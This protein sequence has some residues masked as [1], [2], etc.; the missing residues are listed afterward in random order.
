[1]KKPYASRATP[2]SRLQKLFD[3]GFVKAGQFFPALDDHRAF[4][5]IRILEHELD[6][7]V[8]RGRFLLH[9][10]VPVKRRPGIQKRLD[11]I[12]ADEVAQFLFG[13]RVLA[14]LS[15]VEIN[16]FRLQETSCFAASRSRRLVDEFDLLGHRGPC[17]LE[18]FCHALKSQPRKL[19][20]SRIISMSLSQ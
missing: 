5:Q 12:I 15:F 2:S 20:T 3:F 11:G 14:V 18:K 19:C 1:M 17:L 6:R 13:K 8:F 10:F 7:L 4:Q 16:L 9:V